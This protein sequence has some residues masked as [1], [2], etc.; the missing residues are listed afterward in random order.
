MSSRNLVADETAERNRT[1]GQ[2]GY[3]FNA[4]PPDGYEGRVIVAAAVRIGDHAHVLIDSG[5]NIPQRGERPDQVHRGHAGK[6][7]LAW[8]DWLLLR[9]ILDAD[10]RTRIAEVERPTAGQAW[11]HATGQPE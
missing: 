6:L 9:E 4:F 10:E 5:R 11:R 2:G 8:D 3:T 7:I 1:E